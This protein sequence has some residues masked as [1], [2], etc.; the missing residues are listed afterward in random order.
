[1]AQLEYDTLSITNAV[2]G[3]LAECQDP[4]FKE[5]M[6]SLIKH[7]HDFARDVDL[8]G[9]EWIKAI[10]F[11][12]A[13]GKTCDDKRQEF[14]LLSDTLGLSM[15]V[16]ALEHARALKGRSGATPPTD[17]T[18]QGPFYW[19]GAPELPLGADIAEGVPGEPA[20]YS[21]RVT[22]LE[23]KPLQGALLDI[24]SG[25]GD[26]VYD[27][28]R[29]GSPMRARARI[30]TDAQGR[31]WFWSI[32]PTYYPVPDDGPV[33][34]MLR[35]MGRHPNR[36]GH[37]HMM[38]SA[39]GH[40]RVVTHLFVKNSPYLDSDAVFGVRDSLIVDFEQKEPGTAMDG[41]KMNKP[42]HVAHFD[43]RLIPL[44]A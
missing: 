14:I 9:D 41:R 37:I 2:I 25:D 44:G 11:L 8:Q 29:D 36:P 1:M 6:T 31:Y 27:M 16:V 15:L 22:D 24:W 18:V 35:K 39:P 20:L 4:R 28:Q 13:C 40:T 38:V 42:Y 5:V 12:T 43:F 26:G 7:L 23:G 19:E 33:G 30:R 34:E 3:R 10:G 21:G 32:R 17:A